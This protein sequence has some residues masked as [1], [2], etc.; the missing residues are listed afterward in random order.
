MARH[1]SILSRLRAAESRRHS[2]GRPSNGPWAWE[3]TVRNGRWREVEVCHHEREDRAAVR[4]VGT[5]SGSERALDWIGLGPAPE[6][7]PL[8]DQRGR[9]RRF[10]TAEAAKAAV[11]RTWL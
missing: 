10:R 9:H 3:E 7:A 5:E 8:T 2:A 11:D 1:R 6:R 4:H